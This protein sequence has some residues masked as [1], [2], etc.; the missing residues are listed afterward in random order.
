VALLG[1]DQQRIEAA[2]RQ[3]AARGADAGGE[4]LAG[5]VKHRRILAEI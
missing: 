1:E 5:E 2:P 3:L 4:F